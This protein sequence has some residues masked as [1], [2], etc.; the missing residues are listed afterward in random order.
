MPNFKHSSS[1]V[2]VHNYYT[3]PNIT[4]KRFLEKPVVA[5]KNSTVFILDFLYMTNPVRSHVLASNALPNH[6]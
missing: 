1:S 2:S 5:F 3:V 4:R 6:T